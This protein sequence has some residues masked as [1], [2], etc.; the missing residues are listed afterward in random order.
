M[1]RINNEV[2]ELSR[3][4]VRKEQALARA[5]DSLEEKN[6]ALERANETARLA[7]AMLSGGD[8][9]PRERPRT[10]VDRRG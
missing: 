6:A 7:Q 3:A 9:S 1:T 2:V 5:H 8:L 4:S 10:A